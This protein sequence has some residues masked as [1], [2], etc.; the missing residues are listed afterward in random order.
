MTHFLLANISYLKY[1]LPIVKELTVRDEKSCFCIVDSPRESSPHRHLSGIKSLSDKFGFS[2]AR[3]TDL[4]KKHEVLLTIEGGG[5]LKSMGAIRKISLVALTDFTMTYDTYIDLVNNVIFPSRFFAEHYGKLSPKNLYFGSP[6]YDVDLDYEDIKTK[7]K[8]TSTK[9][10]LVL[11]PRKRDIGNINMTKLY[12]NIHNLG[13]NIIVK[14]RQKDTADISLRGDQYYE[15]FSLFPHTTM[16]LMRVCDFVINFDSTA[17][18]ECVMMDAPVVNFHIK[19]FEKP[20]GFL[21]NYNYCRNLSNNYTEE[22]LKN[23]I[24]FLVSTNLDEE[25]RLARKNH[26]FDKNGVSKKI[27]DFILEK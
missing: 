18:K 19:P 3:N 7:Y 14:T 6:K 10:A 16:E 1:F 27:V 15:D 5:W 20:M 4:K 24:D 9:N 25:F 11:F 13:Y 8:I 22:S 26:L 12:S 21:Y 2:I 23:A 17:I